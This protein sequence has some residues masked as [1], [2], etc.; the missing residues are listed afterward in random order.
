[1]LIDKCIVMLNSAAMHLTD[2]TQE[3]ILA[4]EAEINEHKKLLDNSIADDQVLEKTKA[5]FHDLK[6]L[7]DRLAQLKKSL[8]IRA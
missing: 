1:M 6:V 3:D 8:H 4:M 7:T 2:T 5:I